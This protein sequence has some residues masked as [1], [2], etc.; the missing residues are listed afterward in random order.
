MKTTNTG[1]AGDTSEFD[2]ANNWWM[3]LSSDQQLSLSVQYQIPVANDF[4]NNL[5][6]QR[7][8]NIYNSEH[9][10]GNT[11]SDNKELKSKY[12]ILLGIVKNDASFA[13]LCLKQKQ[14]IE[15]L[16]QALKPF[17]N[18]YKNEEMYPEG[19]IGYHWVSKAKEYFNKQ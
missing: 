2:I 11:P 1:N 13:E 14:R 15:Q 7:I 5:A 10:Q 4:P 19:T 12:N 17:Y 16:E 3:G 6:M 18:H 9:L 8:I